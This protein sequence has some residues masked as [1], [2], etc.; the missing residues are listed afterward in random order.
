MNFA[1][2]RHTL[3]YLLRTRTEGI[4]YWRASSQIELRKG[5]VPEVTI[6][7][8]D[9]MLDGRPNHGALRMFGYTDSEWATCPR[10]RRSMGGA[11][12][13]LAGGVVGYKAMLQPT[14]AM[15]STEAEFME[16][17][18]MG[19]MM[20]YCR[21]TRWVG[22]TLISHRKKFSILKFGLN[23]AKKDFSKK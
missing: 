11:A 13:V 3:K 20:L 2:L 6:N 1:G 18:V 12:L 22:A 17:A 23:T 16:A 4:C 14:V 21:S 19:R 9:L 5:P 15:S 10:T 8:H 7:A